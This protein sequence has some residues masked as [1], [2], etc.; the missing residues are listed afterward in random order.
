M[1]AAATLAPVVRQNRVTEAIACKIAALGLLSTMDVLIK[2]MGERDIP[3]VQLAFFRATVSIL[4]I[5]LFIWYDG[6]IVRLRVRRWGLL[7]ARSLVL[8]VA[9]LS[10]F[11]SFTVR[12]LVNIYAIAYASPLII[13]AL[14]VPVLGESVGPRRWTA[15]IV[16]FLGVLVMLRPGGD[17]VDWVAFLALLATALMALGLV[18]TRLLSETE[19]TGAIVLGFMVTSAMVTGTL[20]LVAT[21][22]PGVAAAMPIPT[23]WVQP[24]GWEWLVLVAIGVVGGMGQIAMTQ[25]YR[26]GPASAIAQ[27]EYSAIVWAIVFDIS[28]WAIWPDRGVLAGAAVMAAAGLYIFRREAELARRAR[29]D[30]AGPTE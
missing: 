27:F 28:I 23:A 25:A 8:T 29:Q 2:L 20:L 5:A 19:S 11:Y 26:L 18:W 22:S 4:P 21:L 16:G 9:L 12:P 13:T 1:T 3:I 15:V 10:F 17:A 30:A 24:S 7:L 6:G 14:S